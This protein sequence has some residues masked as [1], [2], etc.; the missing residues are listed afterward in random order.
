MNNNFSSRRT[1]IGCAISHMDLWTRIIKE[2]QPALILEDDIV[3]SSSFNE[4]FI[5]LL[6]KI[7][8][9][10]EHGENID[11]IY[12]GFHQYKIVINNE[13]SKY[14]GTSRGVDP[15]DG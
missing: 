11:C 9:T 3:L 14:R 5:S 10:Q 4:N 1:I 6:R 12:L 15:A 7:N 2:S 8:I 13:W